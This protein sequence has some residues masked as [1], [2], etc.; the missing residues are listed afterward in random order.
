MDNIYLQFLHKNFTH[1]LLL[2]KTLEELKKSEIWPAFEELGTI[3]IPH[4]FADENWVH[5]YNE[6]ELKKQHHFFFDTKSLTIY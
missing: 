3:L 1:G 2:P 5:L 4:S 6:E